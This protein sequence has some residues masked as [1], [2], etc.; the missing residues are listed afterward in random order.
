MW[1]EAH[2]F[3]L[4]MKPGDFYMAG[5]TKIECQKRTDKKIWL[6][7]GTIIRL[8]PLDNDSF[9]LTSNRWVKV[10]NRSYNRIEN[11]LRD[12]EGYLI[13]LKLTKKYEAI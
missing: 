4:D 2:R 12:V 13:Y 9:Y 1:N 11:I 3:L 8:R 7:D 10:R 5:E 6:S